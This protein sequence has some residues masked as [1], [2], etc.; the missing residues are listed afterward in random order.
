MTFQL[1]F[2][3]IGLKSQ[4]FHLPSLVDP[5]EAWPWSPTCFIFSYTINFLPVLHVKGLAKSFWEDDIII[6]KVSR[7]WSSNDK[8]HTHIFA[9]LKYNR[10]YCL[11]FWELS[12]FS[13][14]FQQIW[15]FSFKV[16]LIIYLNIWVSRLRKPKRQLK[17]KSSPCASFCDITINL[18]IWK[19]S[20]IVSL[21][22]KW[23]FSFNID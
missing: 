4:T 12:I 14:E 8:L 3:T 9:I 17:N 22:Y 6:E 11:Q 18:P 5:A 7:P 15:Y 2:C 1:Q 16:V 21:T 20:Y 19:H 23:V 10:K 13:K